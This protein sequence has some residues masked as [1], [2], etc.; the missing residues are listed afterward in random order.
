MSK[1]ANTLTDLIVALMG[2]LR[3]LNEKL[4]AASLGECVKV[5]RKISDERVEKMACDGLASGSPANNPVVPDGAQ[6]VEFCHKA[7]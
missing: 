5:D 1:K 6:I 7:R 3:E 2:G 4:E